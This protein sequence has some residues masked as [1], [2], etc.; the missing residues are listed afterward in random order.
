MNAFSFQCSG[1]Q[2]S[3]A[4]VASFILTGILLAGNLMLAQPH[5]DNGA[6]SKPPRST[7]AANRT[8][9]PNDLDR[10]MALRLVTHGPM[11]SVQRANAIGGTEASQC[12]VTS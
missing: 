11:H 6:V 7:A 2:R 5:P 3:I 9:P 10:A 1:L 8:H 12:I 4:L